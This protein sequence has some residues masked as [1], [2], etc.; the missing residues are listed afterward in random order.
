MKTLELISPAERRFTP[1]I[2]LS[3][4]QRKAA[5]GVLLGLERGDCVVLRDLAS[6][7]K[8]TVLGY[9]HEKL[10]GV[11]IG[12]REF[13]AKLA[14]Y[15]PYAIEEAFLDLIDAEIA[16]HDLVIV[17]DLHLIKNVVES[18]DYT[19]KNL[20]DAVMTAALASASTARKKMLFATG[21]IPDPLLR[22][23]H[24]WFIEDFTGADFETICSAYL[25]PAVCRRLDFAELHRYAPSLN[26][27]QLRRAAV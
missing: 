2:S 7:G 6:D 14:A 21:E 5:E 20:F 17:D 15:E 10:G 12:V 13:L 25:D 24:S 22:R 26:A 9:I 8:T 16:R 18:C 11:R 1:A 4:S 19:R 27:H 23:A 3:P